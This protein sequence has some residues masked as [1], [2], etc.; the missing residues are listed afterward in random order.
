MKK[1]ESEKLFKT[2]AVDVYYFRV[3]H[4]G[5]LLLFPFRY[6]HGY[7]VDVATGG[8]ETFRDE[9]DCRLRRTVFIR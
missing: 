3:C 6:G 5:K 2:C 4:G 8:R 7:L 9:Y 1:Y